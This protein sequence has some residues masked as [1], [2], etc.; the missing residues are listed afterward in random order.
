VRGFRPAL[1][2]PHLRILDETRLS[3]EVNALLG[4]LEK[5]DY[6]S[7]KSAEK[8]FEQLVKL[9]RN[10]RHF[11]AHNRFTRADPASLDR[12]GLAK[13]AS[14]KDRLY[15]ALVKGALASTASPHP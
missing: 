13:P 9:V 10:A 2:L 6:P 15:A 11:G 14:L 3:D 7:G 4:A 5:G 12:L 1:E 8:A